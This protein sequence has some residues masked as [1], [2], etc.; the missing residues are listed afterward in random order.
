MIEIKTMSGNTKEE[1]DEISNSILNIASCDECSQ[2]AKDDRKCDN[3]GDALCEDCCY[4]DED[5][6]FCFGCWTER[7]KEDEYEY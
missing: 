1:V 5:I 7:Q 6:V 2:P 3:C 4:T